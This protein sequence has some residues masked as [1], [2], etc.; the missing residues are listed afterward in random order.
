MSKQGQATIE[1]GKHFGFHIYATAGTEE[2]R[3]K[4]R[5]MGCKVNSFLFFYIIYLLL[6][7]LL[8][9]I[10]LLSILLLSILLLSI[11][12]LLFIIFFYFRVCMIRIACS[13]PRSSLKTPTGMV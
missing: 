4:L 2:K 11:L 12:L 6:F 9:F 13:G 3:A 8:L 10:L 5:E 7:I 1:L